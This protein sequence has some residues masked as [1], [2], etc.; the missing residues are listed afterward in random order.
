MNSC[1]DLSIV[2]HSQICR[3]ADQVSTELQ[4]EV[5]ILNVKEGK[6]YNLNPVGSRIWQMIEQP[7]S[8]ET[9]V[10][11]ILEEYNVERQRCEEDVCKILLAMQASGLVDITP[12]T[13]AAADPDL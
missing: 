13:T 3:S 12:S 10:N 11:A 6:Y 1:S 9:I 8:A 7:A 5:V 2:I 4:G